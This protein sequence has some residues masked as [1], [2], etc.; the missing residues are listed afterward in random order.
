[1]EPHERR[2]GRIPARGV[3]LEL[4]SCEVDRTGQDRLLITHGDLERHPSG[5][6]ADDEHRPLGHYQ[7]AA[8][9]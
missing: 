2:P 5:I 6:V 9:P 1:M 3:G 4:E 7:P 8:T